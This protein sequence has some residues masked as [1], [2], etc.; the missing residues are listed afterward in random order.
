MLRFQAPTEAA[1]ETL[2]LYR[3]A[4]PLALLR[5]R[6]YQMFAQSA[7][8][9][10]V[11]PHHLCEAQHCLPKPNRFAQR[12]C[13]RLHSWHVPKI[14]GRSYSS[15]TILTAA[16]RRHKLHIVRFRIVHENS[17]ISLLLLFPKSLWTFR[18]PCYAPFFRPPDAVACIAPKTRRP[19]VQG[20]L[21]TEKTRHTKRCPE[22]LWQV[23]PKQI[24]PK[25][26]FFS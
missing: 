5:C 11:S 6:L 20:Q 3:A 21:N 24:F 15:L 10:G 7:T 2:N 12:L 9:L 1:A 16:P 23:A 13:L 26:S 19:S 17:L 8:S 18:E 22:I 4:E 25:K 14:V